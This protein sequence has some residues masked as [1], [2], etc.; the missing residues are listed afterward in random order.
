MSP[1]WFASSI[2]EQRWHCRDGHAVADTHRADR[3]WARTSQ[4]R[5][6][7]DIRAGDDFEGPSLPDTLVEWSIA[8]RT[9]E[10]PT[11]LAFLA[12]TLPSWNLHAIHRDRIVIT[13]EG[14]RDRALQDL[15]VASAP[16]R[17]GRVSIVSAPEAIGDDV[18]W[19][20]ALTADESR[21]SDV[22]PLSFPLAWMGG[23]ASVLLHEAVGHPSERSARRVALPAWL[24]VSDDPSASH[25]GGS[26]LDDCG[27]SL[28]VR[29]LTLN[30]HPSA[31]RRW[32]FRDV[33][34]RRMTNLVVTSRAVAQ[35]ELPDPRVEIHLVGGGH[36]DALDDNIT[37]EVL[38]ADL[39]SGGERRRLTPFR[40]RATRREVARRLEGAFGDLTPYRGVIC[41]DEG[42]H[43]PV[44]SLAV[45][46][47]T[48]PR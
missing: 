16:Y 26:G 42:Q 3:G 38:I 1:S 28:Q 5:R 46:I 14:A 2:V 29:D 20:H 22:D 4:S 15:I 27:A 41:S 36:W 35:A 12:S 6:R 18:S 33:P 11:G 31:L 47:V 45:G 30:E 34:L 9:Y 19:L 10:P 32:S 13:D 24:A 44:G 40:Y 8:A 23:S 7:I 25:L 39:V 43:L 17:H 21:P 37:V 48:G